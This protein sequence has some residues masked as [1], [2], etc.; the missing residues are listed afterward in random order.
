[1]EIFIIAAQTADGF[2]ARDANHPA[3]WTSK[4]DKKRFV[5]LTKDAGVVVM[6]STTFKTLPRPLKERLNVVYSNSLKDVDL[7]TDPERKCMVTNKQPADLVENLAQLGYT[8]IAI[9]GGS[10]VYSLFIESGLVDKV[11]L[12]VEP[13]LFGSGISVFK[14][15]LSTDIQMK[16]DKSEVTEQGTVFLDYTILK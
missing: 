5:E 14:R 13:I 8:K 2:I 11:Y 3:V 1:M 10:E 6:G 12:T 7:N 15:S 16:L 9:C 4:E